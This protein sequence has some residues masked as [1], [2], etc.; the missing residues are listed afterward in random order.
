MVAC[1]AS[2]EVVLLD[3][4]AEAEGATVESDVVAVD[5]LE[6]ATDADVAHCS[7]SASSMLGRSATSLVP[8]VA[9]GLGSSALVF[10][11]MCSSAV[12]LAFSLTSAAVGSG[13]WTSIVGAA[14][15]GTGT[16][17]RACSS[18]SSRLNF[19]ICVRP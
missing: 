16:A 6:V 9:V 19:S 4:V 10:G 1:A 14:T 3:A 18:A 7:K 2:T 5:A 17:V 11:W 12:S 15:T 13:A 8:R